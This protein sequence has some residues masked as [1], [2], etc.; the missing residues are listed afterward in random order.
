M[1]PAEATRAK[2][3]AAKGDAPVKPPKG[4]LPLEVRNQV[5]KEPATGGLKPPAS[6]LKQDAVLAAGNCY[7][8][9]WSVGSHYSKGQIVSYFSSMQ[10]MTEPHDFEAQWATQGLPPLSTNAWK[11]LGPCYVEPTG[12]PPV[13]PSFVWFSPGSGTL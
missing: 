6:P 12:P 2:V 5:T 10:G 1:V 7:H 11:D 13:P 8:Q 4:A 9:A 3:K